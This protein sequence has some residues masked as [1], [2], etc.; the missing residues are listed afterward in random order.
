MSAPFLGGFSFFAAFS[1]ALDCGGCAGLGAAVAGSAV[2]AAVEG[3]VAVGPAEGW[4][5][6]GGGAGTFTSTARDSST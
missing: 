6:G 2:E 5:V 3:V 4:E 1:E